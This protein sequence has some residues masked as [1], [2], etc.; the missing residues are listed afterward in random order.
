MDGK[1]EYFGPVALDCEENGFEASTLPNPSS[2]VFW[3]RIQTEFNDNGN[4]QIKDLNGSVIL[5]EELTLSQGI[6]MFPIRKQLTPGMYLIEVQTNKG[7]HN[8]IKHLSN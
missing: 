5:M 1:N 3:L 2:D 8:V 7:K 6:N 4:L